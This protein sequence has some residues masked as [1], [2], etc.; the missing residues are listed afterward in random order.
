[1]PARSQ[2]SLTRGERPSLRVFW[3]SVDS[4]SAV[5]VELRHG[6]RWWLGDV[7]TVYLFDLL[8]EPEIELVLRRANLV[9]EFIPTGTFMQGDHCRT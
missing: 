4:G 5:E 6:S 1:M 7:Y 2:A 8:L 3:R 9:H